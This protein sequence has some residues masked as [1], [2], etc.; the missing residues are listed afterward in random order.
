MNSRS[1]FFTLCVPACILLIPAGAMLFKVEGWA[2]GPGDFIAAWVLLA[3]V[4][5]AYRLIAQKAANS[6]AG[7]SYRLATGVGLGAGF[8]L[9]W[10]NGAVGLIGSEENPANLLYGG[11]LAVGAVCAALARLEPLG[12]ARALATTALAQFLVPVVALVIR[13]DDFGPGIPQVFAL[14]L[15]FVL[16]FA[17]SALLYRHAGRRSDG[18]GLQAV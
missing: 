13:P 6:A 8:L 14:N 10:V 5:L 12:M 17:V 2:W 1:L 18:A 11:V 3:G 9:L 15:G 16:L 4:G 7:A